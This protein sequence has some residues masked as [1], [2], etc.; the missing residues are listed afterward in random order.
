MAD[1]TCGLLFCAAKRRGAFPPNI[2]AGLRARVS[3][4]GDFTRPFSGKL[5]PPAGAR[6]FCHHGRSGYQPFS[7]VPNPDVLQG[8]HSPSGQTA[9][10]KTQFNQKQERLIAGVPPKPSMILVSRKT[11]QKFCSNGR[12]LWGCGLYSVTNLQ[13]C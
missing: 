5:F 8:Q 7:L 13:K 6:L 4:L 3:R 1:G 2:P 11:Y 10:S 9:P 12:D